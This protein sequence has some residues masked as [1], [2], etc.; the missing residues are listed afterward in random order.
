MEYDENTL[1]EIVKIIKKNVI[2]AKDLFS[3]L[4]E[5]EKDIL[6]SK[7]LILFGDL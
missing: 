6:R 5:N 3:F 2:E 7:D 4:N 1:D